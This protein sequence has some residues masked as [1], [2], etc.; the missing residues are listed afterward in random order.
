MEEIVKQKVNEIICNILQVRE[1]EIKPDSDLRQSLS[2]NNFDVEELLISL[3]GEFG[4]VDYSIEPEAI[5]K[6]Q[7]VYDFVENHLQ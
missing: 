6:V 4:L 5:R 7:N 1:N 2:A 3:A